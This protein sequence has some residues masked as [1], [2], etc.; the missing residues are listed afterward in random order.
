MRDNYWIF[1]LVVALIMAAVIS[2]YASPDP[3]G[4]ER[5]AEDKGFLEHGEGHEVMESPMPDYIIPGIENEVLSASLAGVTG[6]LMLF[7]AG[8][9]LGKAFRGGTNNAT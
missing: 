7:G 2:L 9:L 6:T 4:L 8:I 1:G 3:D 5:V